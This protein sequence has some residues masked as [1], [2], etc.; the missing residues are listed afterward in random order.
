MNMKEQEYI[1]ALA[2]CGSIT[3]A[4]KLLFIT[5]P[6]LSA[7]ISGVERSLGVDLFDRSGKKLR[8]TYAG[9]L[10]V[11]KAKRMLAMKKEYMQEVEDV[12]RG[13][14]GRLCIGMQR[15]RA[16]YLVVEI[17]HQFRKKFPQVDL[18][19]KVGIGEE[20]KRQ[21]QSRKIDILIQNEPLEAT[22]IVQDILV[23][24]KVLLVVSRRD[25]LVEKG[26]Y[27]PD[28]SYRW[29]DV[30]NLRD[31]II[32][33]TAEGQSLRVD[34]DHILKKAGIIPSKVIEIG[35]IDTATQLAA[36]GYGVSFTRE[37][38]ATQ[39]QYLKQPEF[40]AVGTP[41]EE[42]PL[43]AIYREDMAGNKQISYAINI[44]RNIVKETFEKRM[45]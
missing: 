43:Y 1:C 16:P 19:F 5:Q 39:F 40:F 24:E 12:L 28:C 8:L 26:T 13:A 32:I 38:Y 4:A 20:L 44:I 41:I 18:A 22:H 15:R 35:H 34:C 3:K 11:E 2:E 30:Q 14:K 45:M 36:E 23:N 25:T 33:L 37:S 7:Y 42:R 21:F 27:L 6:A 31:R 10:Y 17:M 9:E 29:M